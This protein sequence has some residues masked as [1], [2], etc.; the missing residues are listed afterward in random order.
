VLR[1][2][3]RFVDTQPFSGTSSLLFVIIPGTGSV[4]NHPEVFGGAGA[5]DGETAAEQQ[6]E[7]SLGRKLGVEHDGFSTPVVPD[8]G[9][10]RVAERSVVVHGLRLFV[11]AGEPLEIV[12]RAEHGV[13]RAF[14][15][16]G[17][18]ALGLALV[19]SYLAGA[20]F[21]RP[22]RR[23]AGV[24]TLVDDGDLH[25]RMTLSGHPSREVKVLAESFN[26][27]LDRLADAFAAQR[28]FV[29]DA[30]HELRTPLTVIAGQLEV[31][32]ATEEPTMT[33]IRRVERLVA[34]EVARTARLVDDLLV[35]AQSDRADFLHVE[36][37]DLRSFVGDLWQ[38]TRHLA[39]RRYELGQIPA[40]RLRADP[41]RLAQAVR[42][43][44][45]NAID[46]T[47]PTAGRIALDVSQLSNGRVVLVVADD[48]P[49]IPVAHR[50]HVFERFHRVDAARSRS[51][52]GSGLG[53][54]IVRAIADAH[55]GSVSAGASAR[56][57]GAELRLELPGFTP[58]RG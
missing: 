23:I 34:G 35:L 18:M 55:G 14:V 19:A 21:S 24:A 3:S 51:H 40:G 39:D 56:L 31:L 47:Q 13:A 54:A 52:G 1:A 15:L 38:S 12:T 42:N 46:H 57:G 43:L 50:D 32:A 45:G 6:R 27:M 16:A 25:P 44:V 53:L 58:R 30:S 20:V 11:G 10:M 48:G 4:S 17:A 37:L 36:D 49:G 29:A 2:A 7:N 28:D 26:H 8:V 22:L 5:D 41:D 33:E 9:R